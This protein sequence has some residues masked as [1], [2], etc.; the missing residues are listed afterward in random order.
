MA[1][2][3]LIKAIQ[4]VF[5]TGTYI[6]QR[7][8]VLLASEFRK[9]ASSSLR[10]YLTNRELQIISL[11]G[12]GKHSKQIA[13]ELSVSI[14]TVNTYRTRIFAKMDL[15]SNAELIRYA[16]QHGLVD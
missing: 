13:A 1:A 14:S 9:S 3:E 7:V 2:E 4:C 5:S 6:S 16:I 11:L 10:N 15:R 8:A 12:A